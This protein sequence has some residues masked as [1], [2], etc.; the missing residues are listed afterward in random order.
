M[1]KIVV[2]VKDTKILDYNAE[3]FQEHIDEIPY[4]V[5]CGIGA[6]CASKEE[7]VLRD[8]ADLSKLNDLMVQYL[9]K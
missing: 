7:I 1:K 9:T 4:M 6:I 2:K 3:V 5:M 8:Y